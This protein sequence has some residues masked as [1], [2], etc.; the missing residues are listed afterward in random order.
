MEKIDPNQS[1]DETKAKLKA[2]REEL[3]GELEFQLHDIEQD[4]TDFAKQVLLIGG[5]LYLS[6]RLLKAVTGR[7]KKKEKKG[8]RKHRR[9]YAEQKK[10]NSSGIGRMLLQQLIS[11]G[12]MAA[13]Y[14]IKQ[15]LKPKETVHD[16]RK[17]P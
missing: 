11:M 8:K 15:A 10:S 1:I 14:Q 3:E 7:T 5:G 4:A 12:A 17:N 9:Y 6:W 2:S 16:S 13:T